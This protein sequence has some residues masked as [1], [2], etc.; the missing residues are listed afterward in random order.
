MKVK[1]KYLHY[2]LSLKYAIS[3]YPESEG[4]AAIIKDLPGCMSVGETLSEATD[5]IEEAR[6][7]W[8]ETAYECGDEIPL[9]AADV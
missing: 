8:V 4:Y 9:P 6:E 3:F 2:Y 7:L 1:L 5:N